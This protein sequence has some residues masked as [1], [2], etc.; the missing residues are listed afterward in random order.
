MAIFPKVQSDDIVQVSDK[1]RIDAT[2]SFISKDEA[3]ITLVE[4]EPEGGSGFIDVTGTSL[5]DWYL[6]WEYA[7]DGDKTVSVRITTDGAPSTVTKTVS[8]LTSASDKLFSDDDD[9]VAL[10][11]DIMKYI[12]DGR[13]TFKYMHREAQRQILEY[14]NK[15]SRRCSPDQARLEKGNIWNIEEVRYWSKYLVYRLLYD[16]FSTSVGD[17]F[18][19]RSERFMKEEVFWR[20]Q[21]GIF[22]DLDADGNADVE[23][24]V[25]WRRLDRV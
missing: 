8:C 9:L 22:L 21:A 5:K 20:T 2:R 16:D 14:F 24:D 18:Q 19:I 17:F 10:E 1:F 23:F 6:D 13:N 4:I 25:T 11:S 7:T 3:A 15:I 12:P